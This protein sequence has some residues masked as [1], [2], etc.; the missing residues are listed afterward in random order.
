M[1]IFDSPFRSLKELFLQI[2]RQKTSFPDF[3]LEMA[4]NYLK[5]IVMEKAGFDIEQVDLKL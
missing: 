5:P 2:G 1:A 3:I 4:Y